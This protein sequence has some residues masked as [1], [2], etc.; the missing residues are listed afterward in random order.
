MKN[1]NENMDQIFRDRLN[2]YESSSP[3]HLWEK[4]D[5]RRSNR[6]KPLFKPWQFNLLGL[7]LLL[8]SL[9]IGWLVAGQ[10]SKDVFNAFQLAQSQNEIAEVALVTDP[11][12]P[13]DGHLAVASSPLEATAATWKGE[14][15]AVLPTV[16]Q[17]PSKK[18]RTSFNTTTDLTTAN[19]TKV[20]PRGN[21]RTQLTAANIISGGADLVLTATKS[22]KV[23]QKE[24]DDLIEGNTVI[25]TGPPVVDEA[26]L[27]DSERHSARVMLTTTEAELLPKGEGESSP[28][29]PANLERPAFH[30][31]EALYLPK[32]NRLSEVIRQPDESLLKFKPRGCYSFKGSRT[33]YN[34]FLDVFYS[35]DRP[36]RSMSAKNAEYL[37]YLEARQATETA[38]HSNSTGLRVSM[39]SQE[40]FA[41]R[42]GLVYSQITEVFDYKNENEVRI[43]V[44]VEYE[45]DPFSGDTLSSREVI[46]REEGTRLKTTYNKYRMLDIPLILGYEWYFKRFSLDVNAGVYFNVLFKQKGDILSP[47]TYPNLAPVSISSDNPNAQPVF[48]DKLGVSVYGS[49]GLNYN[50]NQDLQLLIEPNFRYQVKS[51]TLDDYILDQRY[52]IPGL[53][54]GV[55]FRI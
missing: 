52:V 31:L 24:S 5:A 48:L 46:T 22:S 21:N 34:I 36:I 38:F 32:Q 4:I 18:T 23:E 39:V 14:D 7:G 11:S 12:E 26:I 9:A 29:L 43:F 37:D 51:I 33:S 40:G 20:E 17:D 3:D 35:L 8:S 19:P 49:L 16:V 13:K 45:I 30:R 15:R 27:P 44:S 28:P 6:K 55:R 1:R 10:H 25:P 42:S 2:D 47:D 54:V 50:L 41:L 53:L